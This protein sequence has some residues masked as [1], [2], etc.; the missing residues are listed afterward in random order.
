MG[1]TLSFLESPVRP[2]LF[3]T[4]LHVGSLF[5]LEVFETRTLVA[6]S[7]LTHCVAEMTEGLPHRVLRSQDFSVTP[8]LYGA[9]DG[10]RVFICPGRAGALPGSRGMPSPSRTCLTSCLSVHLFSCSEQH[11]HFTAAIPGGQAH[12][13]LGQS[14]RLLW[15]QLG[16]PAEVPAGPSMGHE[17]LVLLTGIEL[18]QVRLAHTNPLSPCFYLFNLGCGT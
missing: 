7:G 4:L 9:G 16:H 10:N 6:H 5:G 11:S 15:L 13:S 2:C 12:L 8:R 18:A 3:Q 17:P 14:T 1:H